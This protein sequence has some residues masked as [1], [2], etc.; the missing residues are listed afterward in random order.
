MDSSMQVYLCISNMLMFNPNKYSLKKR[1]HSFLK[2]VPL[3]KNININ[4]FSKSIAFNFQNNKFLTNYIIFGSCLAFEI[5]TLD[6]VK[7]SP[8]FA[9]IEAD[10]LAYI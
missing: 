1:H 6:C 9:N 10:Y 7:K 3:S 8:N 2:N 4:K 5:Y